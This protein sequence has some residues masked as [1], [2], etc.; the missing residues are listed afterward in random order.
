[1]RTPKPLQIAAYDYIKEQ[2]LSDRFKYNKIYSETQV[3]KEIGISRTPVRDAIQKLAHERYIDIIPSKG[4]CIHQLNEQDVIETYQIR[5]ALEG[6]CAYQVALSPDL[7]DHKKLFV[8]LENYQQK[9]AEIHHSTCDIHEFVEHDINFHC[10][11]VA[12][13]NSDAMNSTFSNYI[14]QI[15][16]LAS[17]S[18][19]HEGRMRETIEE[20][21]AIL[22]AMRSGNVDTIYGISLKHLEKPQNINLQE[23]SLIYHGI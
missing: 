3:S 4:F 19:P 10:E 17:L 14:Y 7:P 18:L 9:L 12:S 21:Q 20:H 5:S 11:I 22:D 8:T 2:I 1:M 13:L 6:Y 23:L 15:K 16:R